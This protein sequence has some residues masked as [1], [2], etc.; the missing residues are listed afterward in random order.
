V[1]KGGEGGETRGVN[2]GGKKQKRR[3][4]CRKEKLQSLDPSGSGEREEDRTARKEIWGK[5]RSRLAKIGKEL[6]RRCKKLK[7]F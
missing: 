5:K 7:R 3:G 1:I 4:G 2:R 6:R